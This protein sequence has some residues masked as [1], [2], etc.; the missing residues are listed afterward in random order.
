MTAHDDLV[1]ALTVERYSRPVREA[2]PVDGPTRR[3]MTEQARL[4]VAGTRDLNV[5]DLPLRTLEELREVSG[6]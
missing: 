5:V 6:G 2:G 4:D 3:W 1:R